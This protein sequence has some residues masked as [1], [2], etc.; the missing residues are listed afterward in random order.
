MVKEDIF[1]LT[2]ALYRVTALFPKKEPLKFALRNKALKVFSSLSVSG[3]SLNFLSESEKID[4]LKRSLFYINELNLFFRLA[5]EQKWVD[6][7]NFEVLEKG[8]FEIK[9]ALEKN[10]KEKTIVKKI[11]APKE[12]SEKQREKAAGKEKS[13]VF[14]KN[15]KHEEREDKEIKVSF[16]EDPSEMSALEKNILEK[17][18]GKGKMKRSDIEGFFPHQSTRSLQRKLNTLKNKNLLEIA[19]VGRDT[20]YFQKI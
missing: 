20:F 9:E 2:S 10:L 7:L 12:K 8:Y 17:M 15:E 13:F 5:K 16:F 6:I 1:K 11:I 19:K 4:I 14:P 3:Q 18:K